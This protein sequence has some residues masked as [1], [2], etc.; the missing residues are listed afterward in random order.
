MSILVGGMCSIC[1]HMALVVS[2]IIIIIMYTFS[3]LSTMPK[4]HHMNYL[5]T[6]NTIN[7]YS[8]FNLRL[9]LS[10]LFY[11][12]SNLVLKRQTETANGTNIS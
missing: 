5:R 3:A 1:C 7:L 10:I 2:F 8:M 4:A 12:I 6:R 9:L 11:N